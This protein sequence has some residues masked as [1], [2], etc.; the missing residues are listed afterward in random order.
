MY[1]A[2]LCYL[3][4]GLDIPLSS[5]KPVLKEWGEGTYL[6]L[7]E[8]RYVSGALKKQMNISGFHR[9]DLAI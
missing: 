3:E 7:L 4:L 1:P 8:L 9:L 2:P 6:G 5:M